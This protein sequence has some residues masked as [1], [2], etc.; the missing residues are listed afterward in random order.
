[1]VTFV[2]FLL[3]DQGF[4]GRRNFGAFKTLCRRFV[5]AE[6]RDIPLGFEKLKVLITG[7]VQVEI[8]GTRQTYD[9]LDHGRPW[10]PGNKQGYRKK[11][12]KI[13]GPTMLQ[14]I[15]SPHSIPS[16]K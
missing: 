16:K 10:I 5:D 2:G 4:K 14:L 7:K 12:V 3:C 9:V 1:M 13:W 11:L 6:A 8:D 15:E